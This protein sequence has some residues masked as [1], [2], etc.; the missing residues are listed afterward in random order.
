MR[1]DDGPRQELPD[2][3]T[4]ELQ[5]RRRCARDFGN[6][7][8]ALPAGVLEPSTADA[9]VDAVRFANRHASHLTMRGQGHSSGGQSLNED[10]VVV[11]SRALCRVL[12]FDEQGVWVEAGARW[13]DL[14][15][16]CLAMGRMPRVLPDTLDLSVGGT[17]SLGGIGGQSHRAGAVIDQVLELEVVTGAGE[18]LR[19][20]SQHEA[21]LFHACLGGLGHY[22]VILSARL[23]LQGAAHRVITHEL[24]YRDVESLL[25][26]LEQAAGDPSLDYVG[27]LLVPLPGATELGALLQVSRYTDGQD[28]PAPWTPARRSCILQGSNVERDPFAFFDRTDAVRA[29]L[30]ATSRWMLPHAW[31][32]QFFPQSTVSGYLDEV[33]RVIA[34]A[35]LGPGGVIALYPLFNRTLQQGCL[36]VPDAAQL[37]LCGVLHTCSHDTPAQRRAQQVLVHTLRGAGQARGATLYPIGTLPSVDEWPAHFGFAW[38]QH[39]ARKRRYD[40]RRVLARAHAVPDEQG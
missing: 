28:T 16:A 5:A 13:R 30:E 23:R 4:R 18:R 39:C 12:D 22:A 34:P 29:E 7:R 24:L 19:C 40:P 36:R 33:R 8:Y 6:L 37:M 10:G 11:D 32:T 21:D 20:S 14:L 35:D 15:R 26:A 9:V 1:R 2:G 3:T 31:S 38:A 25:A 27:G 17:L